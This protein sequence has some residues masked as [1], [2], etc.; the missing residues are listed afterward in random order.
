MQEPREHQDRH[1][2]NDLRALAESD[3]AMGSSPAVEA[4]LLTEVRSL[5]R[6]SRRS[7]VKTSAIAAALI[8]VLIVPIQRLTVT[9]DRSATSGRGPD[10]PL[11][12]ANRETVPDALAGDVGFLPL[13]YSHVPMSD[14]V[15]V[16]LQMSRGALASLGITSASGKPLPESVSADVVVGSDGLA[17]AVRFVPSTN[18]S[19]QEQ[20]P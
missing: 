9:I 4:R 6:A 10:G 11:I 20:E 8:G 16:R 19:Q 17:R 14:G 3:R 7:L 12:S 1:L 18:G 13:I 2:A 5:R 15:V